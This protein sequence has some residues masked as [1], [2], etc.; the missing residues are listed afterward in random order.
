M[1]FKF[2]LEP[3]LKVREH[4]EKVQRQKLAEEMKRKQRISEQKEAVQADLE[5]FLGQKD[6]H[7][8]YDVQKLRNSYAH[9]EHSHNVMGKLERDMQ[10]AEDAIHKERNKLVTAHRETHIME[11]AKDREFSAWKED[12]ERNEQKAMDEIATQYYNR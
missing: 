3:V 10:K 7:K 2:S 9:L 8:V 1:S 4:R 11:K 12:L 6:K 5:Q